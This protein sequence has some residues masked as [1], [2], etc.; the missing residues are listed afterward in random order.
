MKFALSQPVAGL[1]L[2]AKDVELLAMQ[3]A[4]AVSRVRVP[5]EGTESAHLVQ[6]IRQAVAVSALKTNKCAIAMP[7]GDILVRFFLMPV[8]PKAER[9]TAVQ[10][11]ARKYVPFKTDAL[12]WDYY[13]VESKPSGKL[14][15]IFTAVQRSIFQNLQAV[16]EEAGIQPTRMEPRSLSLA[17]LAASVNPHTMVRMGV[18]SLAPTA[19]Q[20]VCLVDVEQTRAHLV[21]ARGGV[22]YLTR[23]VNLSE[24]AT[25]GDVAGGGS[26][27]EKPAVDPKARRLFSELRVSMDFFTREYPAA[28]IPSVVLIGDEVLIEPWRQWLADQLQCAVEIG[29]DLLGRGVEGELPLSFAAAVGLVRGGK[30]SAGTA[31]DFLKRSATKPMGAPAP[32]PGG[33]ATVAG[34]IHQLRSTQSLVMGGLAA[35]LLILQWLVGSHQVATEQRWLTQLAHAR[36]AGVEALA[37]MEE[38]QLKPIQ[39]KAKQQ[40]EFLKQ[41]ID[42]RVSVVAKLDALAR[43]LSDGMWLTGLEFEGRPDVTGRSQVTL[44]VNGACYLEQPGKELSAIQAFEAR[45][46]SDPALFEGFTAARVEQIREQVKD[47]DQRQYTYRTFQLNCRGDR[48]L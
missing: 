37:G 32:T 21:I 22:P 38:A 24:E 31:L 34:L 33:P 30:S 3:G 4:R 1:V 10:F 28:T 7:T 15:V 13:A 23:D 18:K 2:R 41:L 9:E 48:R 17:R 27:A 14:E 6:A 43:S 40:V 36:P 39:D 11:E 44:K 29:R 47:Q 26:S 46:K 45:I 8:L 20:F 5:I 25:V 35:G 16:L 42:G 12:V 19:N